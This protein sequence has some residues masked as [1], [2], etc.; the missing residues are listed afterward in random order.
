MERTGGNI[1]NA[2]HI[3]PNPKKAFAEIQHG[4]K[5]AI[6]VIMQFSTLVLFLSEW[7]LFHPFGAEKPW[8]F[9]YNS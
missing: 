1:S 6:I 7:S 3:M 9:L 4:L 2:L 8:P 5:G